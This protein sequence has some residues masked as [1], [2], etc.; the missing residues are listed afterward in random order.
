VWTD[1]SWVDDFWAQ[2][3][4]HIFSREEDGV[5]ILPPNRVY[6]VNPTAASL[7]AYLKRG[8]SMRM[9]RLPS[10][11]A[12][13]DTALFFGDVAALYRGETPV[14]GT[15]ASEQ[16]S[17]SFTRL[18]VLGEIALTYRCNNACRF[19][20]AGCGGQSG[21]PASA[22][23]VS[24]HPER[25]T[26]D[27]R[28]VIDI[29]ADE[30]KIPF[31]SFTGGEPTLREDLEA[32]VGYARRRGLITNLVTN[33]T[34]IDGARAA[35]L[36][37]TGLGSAQ[38]SVEGPDEGTHDFL[39]GRAGAFRETLEGIA[40][41]RKA[42]IPT[43]TNTTITR[44]NLHVIRRMPAF[45]ASLGIRRFAM[46]LFIPTFPGEEA[47]RL[48]VSY[49]EIGSYVDAVAKEAKKLSMTFYWYSPTP[50][51][52][53]NPIAR[54]LG[55]KSCAAADGLLSIAPDGSVLPCSSWDE[56]I[57][58]LLRQNFRELWFSETARFFKEK[59]FA[60]TLCRACDS[61]IACQGACPLYW[62]YTHAEPS[63]VKKSKEPL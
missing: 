61:F 57:G 13:R 46:N 59:H 44:G 41:L 55:N 24:N 28:R 63:G 51:C 30:A 23:S 33:G 22:G 53:Y 26:A 52:D 18:P 60:P 17:F 14:N 34:L 54:G 45:L 43:Q 6:K 32:L 16:F 29:F 12:A 21:R 7:I 31:F 3:G 49:E 15:V 10:E 35:R 27:Y 38:V 11:K 48:F 9:L 39:T 20:Y 2:A 36:K 56:P 50:F 40:A 8:G 1:F 47:D 58:N 5:L 4:E 37:K 19:C 42:G 25:S 62:R